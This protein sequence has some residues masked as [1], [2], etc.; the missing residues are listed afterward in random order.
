MASVPTTNVTMT[1]INNVFRA[2]NNLGAYSSI[3]NLEPG[4]YGQPTTP[5]TMGIFRGQ[6]VLQPPT[7]VTLSGLTTTGGTLSWTAPTVSALAGYTYSIGTTV[8]GSEITNASTF[9][10]SSPLTF[11]AT[12]SPSTTKYYAEILTLNSAGGSSTYSFFDPKTLSAPLITWFK[13]D[14][15]LTTTSWTNNGTNGGSATLNTATIATVNK[16]SACR[17][18]T[19]GSSYGTFSQSFSGQPRAFFAVVQFNA[20][21]TSQQSFITLD[22]FSGHTNWL[23]TNSGS[24]WAQVLVAAGM[25]VS[26]QSN[27]ETTVNPYPNAAVYSL[28]N[29]ATA[30]NNIVQFNGTNPGLSY[31]DVAQFYFTG[32][33][34]QYL[35]G[36][37]GYVPNV[38][39]TFCEVLCYDGEVTAADATNVNNYLRKKWGLLPVVAT[40]GDV[41]TVKGGRKFHYFNNNGTFTLTSMFPNI[42]FEVFCIGGGGGAGNDHGGG[43]GAGG[44]VVYASTLTTGTYAI[45]IGQGGASG[46]PGANG[47]NTTFG[48]LATALGGGGGGTYAGGTGING[49]NGGCGGGANMSGYPNL[50]A[51]TGS[52]GGNGGTPT[53]QVGGGGTGGGGTGGS[54]SSGN[55]P[56]TSGIGTTYF[57]SNYGGGGAGYGAS[58]T[59]YGGAYGGGAGGVYP[60]GG[61]TAGSPNT[62]GGG[63]GYFNAGA[64]GGS[65][66]C[67]VS[68]VYP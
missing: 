34:T 44:K 10:Q 45:T 1:S 66:I 5:L 20:P 49:Q 56:Y 61:H 51:G 16:M 65:G 60:T 26:I 35:G 54:G 62:G 31:S 8:G 12:L 47:G 58:S 18:A 23:L 15:G 13:G 7:A 40:G 25:A 32:A 6:K 41:I 29:S 55:P 3:T 64:A 57:G 28:V 36:Y 19:P 30:A 38:D 48:S 52:Q 37:G 4:T 9:N 33:V 59:S 21:V 43:G 68:Y 27:N 46:A 11:K 14:S 50:T 67:I 22:N 24:S 53:Y 39:C 2:G 17:F 63:G 42:P